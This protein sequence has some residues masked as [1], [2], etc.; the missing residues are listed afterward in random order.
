LSM[1]NRK[2][3]PSKTAMRNFAQKM[4]EIDRFCAEHGISQSRSSDSYYFWVGDHDYRVSNHT[5]EQSFLNSHGRHHAG[6]RNKTTVYIHASKTRIIE[7]YN[8]L[9][10]GKKLN[11][12]G[13]V[14]EG[15]EK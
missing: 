3:T 9:L 11:G 5:V 15:G 2:W 10:A 7:I 1:Y 8:N 4:A 12:F 14:I 6:G 13:E